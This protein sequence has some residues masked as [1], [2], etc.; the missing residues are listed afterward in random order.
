[1]RVLARAL[2]GTKSKELAK[3]TLNAS[4]TRD[5]RRRYRLGTRFYSS[6]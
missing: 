2:L 3:C 4:W 5:A 6:D 1:M